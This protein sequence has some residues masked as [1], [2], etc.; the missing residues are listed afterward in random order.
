MVKE[1]LNLDLKKLSKSHLLENLSQHLNGY[2]KRVRSLVRDFD[3]RSRDAR[4]KSRE[5]LDRFADRLREARGNVETK[6]AAVL[7]QE[8][9]RLNKGVQELLNYLKT[10][11]KSEKLSPKV[12]SPKKR[13]AKVAQRAKKS[14]AGKRT[15][16]SAAGSEARA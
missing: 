5:Q 3:L 1:K 7:N 13:P 10:A 9:Q 4:E 15:R 12:V 8:G 16:K 11:S 14:S 6:V 2:E